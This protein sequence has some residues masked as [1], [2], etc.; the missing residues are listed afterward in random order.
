[1]KKLFIFLMLG[2]LLISFVSAYNFDNVKYEKDKTFD[3]KEILGNNLLEK[4]K[5]IEIKNAFGLGETLFEGYISKHDETCWID[6][7]S[8]MEI[9][10]NQDGVLIDDIIFKT[11]QE[12]NS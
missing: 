11:L 5:P 7:S 10:L 2:I 8:T 1:M 9:K 12:D 4:Y 6:C 3:G